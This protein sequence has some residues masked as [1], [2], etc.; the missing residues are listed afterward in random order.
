MPTKP[1]VKF[2]KTKALLNCQSR[3][4]S[5]ESVPLKGGETDEVMF[6]LT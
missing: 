4:S 2:C 5:Y 6:M 3:D 1:R